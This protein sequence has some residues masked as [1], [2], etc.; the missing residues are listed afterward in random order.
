MEIVQDRAV[1]LNTR[2]P[3]LITEVIPNSQVVKQ[4][5]LPNGQTGSTVA[6]KWTLRNT[7]LLHNLGFK[8]VP[9]PILSLIHI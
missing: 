7:K 6:V 5:A 9:S 4:V 3:H 8:K 2:K 1:L